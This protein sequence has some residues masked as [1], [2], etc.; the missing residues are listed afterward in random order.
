MSDVAQVRAKLDRYSSEL[1]K[2]SRELFDI[3]K[4]LEP[5][6]AEYQQFVADFEVGLWLQSQQD[7]GPKLPS[8]ALR[9]KLAHKKMDA[10]LLGRRQGLIMQRD[11]IQERIRSVK[12]L[13][14]AQRSILSAL[15]TE[16]EALA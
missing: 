1:D 16:L 7:D 11:R 2:M 10:A 12:S 4:A 15:K 14:D 8:E 13:V 6:E 3:E 5:V 9:T